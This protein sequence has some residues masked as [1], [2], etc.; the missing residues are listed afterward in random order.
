MAN[1]F[2]ILTGVVV[3]LAV[4]AVSAVS[5][6]AQDP[7]RLPDGCS[8]YLTVHSKACRVTHYYTCQGDPD[9]AQWGVRYDQNGP[10]YQSQIGAEAEWIQSFDFRDATEARLMPDP[11]DPAEFSKLARGGYDSFDFQQTEAQRLYTYKGHDRLTGETRVIDD[12]PLLVTNF[13]ITQFVDGQVRYRASGQ[14]FISPEFRRFF[15]GVVEWRYSDGARS[16]TNN[17]PIE[18]IFPGE[19]GFLSTKPK[20]ECEAIV[21]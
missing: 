20:Y 13:E 16:E 6:M 12:V 5:A 1:V 2:G 11:Q 10:Y 19:T 17:T 18:F 4:S 8:A 15:G 9:G 21:G 7:A 3:A 14:E